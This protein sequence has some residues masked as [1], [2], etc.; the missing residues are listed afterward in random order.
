MAGAQT[1]SRPELEARGGAREIIGAGVVAGIIGGMLMA[2]IMMMATAAGGMGL[3]A[4][5]RLIAATFYG[6]DAMTGGGPLIVGLMAHVMSSMVFGVIFTG[7]A[8]RRLAALPALMG[9]V[10]FGV[11]IWAVMT[12]GGLP[13][14]NPMMRGRVAMM[15]AVWFVAHVAFGMGVGSAPALR[16]RIAAA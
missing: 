10:A 15:P 1:A 12:F 5:L 2:M 11:A 6:K 13:L 9:G 7:I 14:L 4:P 3:L 8:G 16:R